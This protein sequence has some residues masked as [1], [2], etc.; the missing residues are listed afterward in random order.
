MGCLQVYSTVLPHELFAV[1]SLYGLSVVVLLNGHG[2]SS[3]GKQQQQAHVQAGKSQ[4][5]SPNIS[6]RVVREGV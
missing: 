3:V 1:I 6:V 2:A 4:C 5:S